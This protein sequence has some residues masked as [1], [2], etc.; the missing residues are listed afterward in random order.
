VNTRQQLYKKHR[1]SG[2]SGYKAAIESG[3]AH[4]T[5]WNAHNKIEKRIGFDQILTKAGLDNDS[6]V[7]IAKEG[8]ESLKAVGM[9]GRLI[10]DYKTRHMY[11]DTVL[12]LKGLLKSGTTNIQSVKIKV[13]NGNG[14]LNGE[15]KAK[16]DAMRDFLRERLSI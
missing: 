8:L 7:Q 2:M 3:Y 14:K 11:F 1:L 9:A 6:L 15:H 4:N 12:K 13:G 5:A 16:Q 10:P